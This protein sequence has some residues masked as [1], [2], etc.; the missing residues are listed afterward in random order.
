[1]AGALLATG[2]AV[3]FAAVLG[4]VAIAASVASLRREG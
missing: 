4:L 2:L 1:L 3:F